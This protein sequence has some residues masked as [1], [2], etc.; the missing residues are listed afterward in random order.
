LTVFNILTL[1]F[2]ADTLKV[3]WDIILQFACAL[4]FMNWTW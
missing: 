4:F 3:A 2:L 1:S